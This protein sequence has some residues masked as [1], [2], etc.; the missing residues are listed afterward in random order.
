MYVPSLDEF[1]SLNFKQKI[2]IVENIQ[3]IIEAQRKKY[4]NKNNNGLL[5]SSYFPKNE[6]KI[7][8]KNTEND[9]SSSI[10]SEDTNNNEKYIIERAKKNIIDIKKDFEEFRSQYYLF[11]INNKRKVDKEKETL[12]D[13]EINYMIETTEGNTNNYSFNY[14]NNYTKHCYY[15]KEKSKNEMNTINQIPFNYSNINIYKKNI[16]KK[17]EKGKHNKLDKNGIHINNIIKNDRINNSYNINCSSQTKNNKKFINS[18]SMRN[19][20][21]SI[22]TINNRYK[23]NKDTDVENIKK[24]LNFSKIGEN[25]GNKNLMRTISN[26]HRQRINTNDISNRL[27]NMHK[28]INEKINNKK[29]EFE[30]EEE[31]KNCSFVPK[32]NEKSKKI[33]KNIKNKIYKKINIYNYFNKKSNI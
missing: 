28:I 20:T 24:K 22:S 15:D 29:K 1:S 16:L 30:E 17:I 5:I 23:N 6:D 12:P 33:V 26:T 3:N 31:M 18:Q 32:I 10:S 19:Y 14:S 9:L 2:Q 11:K 8:I 21:K 27:Y 13:Q 4:L 7:N 25:K